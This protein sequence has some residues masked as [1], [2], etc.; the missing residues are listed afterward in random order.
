MA[1]QKAPSFDGIVISFFVRFWH[2]IG[3]DCHGM[4]VRSIEAKRFLKWTT[5]GLIT[6]LCKFG[7]N[8]DLGNRH[9]ISL[10]NMAYKIYVK[11]LHLHLQLI[12][13]EVIYG[14]KTNLPSPKVHT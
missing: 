4:I 2:I 11:V 1:K 14:D 3:V 12:L 8:N 10:L 7:E 9:P 13:M 5:K 6:L